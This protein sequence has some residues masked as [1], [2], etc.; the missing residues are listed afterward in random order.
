MD[1]YFKSYEELDIHQIMLSDKKRVLTYKNAIF[2]MKEKFKDKI[3]MDVGAGSGILSIFCAQV[4]AKKVYAVEA[5]ILANIIEQVSIENNLQDK[6]E[7]IH[8]KVE[9]IQPD[10]LEKIDIIVSEWMGFYLVHEGMLDS[11]LFARDNFLREDGLLFPAIAKLY[12]T[13]CELPSMY[14]FWDDV[15]GV[16]M[17][18]IGEEY[19]KIKSLKPEVLLLHQDNLL[20]EGKLLAWLDL[21]CISVE[22][23]NQL[24]G[25][26]YVTVCEKDGK[27]QGICIWFAV[28]FPDGSEL[29]TA[30]Y[31][32]ETH[33]KQTAVVLPTNTEVIK[34]EPI[35]F[36][37]DLK[38]D[39]S[40]P[41]RYNIELDLLDAE[42]V[43]HDVPCNCL[44]TK[45]IVTKT[46]VENQSKQ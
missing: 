19:R 12:A 42:E 14:E 31:D 6:I 22:D 4:G 11:I 27:Y 15:Y 21:N 37:L 13:P 2:N 8:N 5:S 7:V 26:N 45:C 25:E 39:T 17:R 1:Q 46:Y 44:M 16:G 38:R 28:E 33:W 3:V 40:N 34:N 20:S 9:D 30:P 35:A 23:I 36:K 41:R 32:E 43:E 18:C 10:S 24:G 29:S